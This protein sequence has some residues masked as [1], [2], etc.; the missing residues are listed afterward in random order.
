MNAKAITIRTV[1]AGC[2]ALCAYG[3][4]YWPV[5]VWCA[6]IYSAGPPERQATTGDVIHEQYVNGVL[7]YTYGP[8]KGA[9]T[10]DTTITTVTEVPQ[11]TGP[12]YTATESVWC[13]FPCNYVNE[14]GDVVNTTCRGTSYPKVKGSPNPTL[15]PAGVNS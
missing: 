6:R 15:C 3:A 11:S 5:N 12:G 10:E 1:T 2:L 7:V 4:C 9:C 13:R 8:E 14:T